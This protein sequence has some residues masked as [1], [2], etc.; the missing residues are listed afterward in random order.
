M[1]LWISR[2]HNSKR[3]GYVADFCPICRK[4]NR[5]QLFQWNFRVSFNSL[6]VVSDKITGYVKVCVDCTTTYPAEPA[7]YPVLCRKL[8]PLDDMNRTLPK[9]NQE[10]RDRLE[11]EN[12]IIHSLN[13]IPDDLRTELM[14]EPFFVLSPSVDA[15]LG[16]FSL[17]GLGYF[18]FITTVGLTLGILLKT[19]VAG[20]QPHGIL[21]AT[22]SIGA[23]LITIFLYKTRSKARFIITF[24]LP[25]LAKALQP[26]KPT[27]AELISLINQMKARNLM[28]GR[29]L[30]KPYRTLLSRLI[31]Q[32]HPGRT[33]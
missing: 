18:F 8:E 19:G 14:R 1:F 6:V 23:G 24:L 21:L 26:L 9:F 25:N 17:D 32:N 27:D 28:I 31:N 5:F 4:V 22:V 33:V 15:K 3:T 30:T 12:Q 20:P 2:S 13:S 29:I 16:S 10:I 11:I 7:I